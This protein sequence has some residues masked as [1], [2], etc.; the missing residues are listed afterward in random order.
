VDW[1]PSGCD[2][3]FDELRTAAEVNEEEFGGAI[4]DGEWLKM[5]TVNPAKA[6]ALDAFVGKLARSLKA[7]ITALRKLDD[8]PT[9]S[10]M[11]T[12]L[13]DVQMVWVGGDLL[14]ASKAILDVYGRRQ[15]REPLS[16][17]HLPS[18]LRSRRATSRSF[19]FPFD[20][21]A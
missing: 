15:F 19:E 1:N 20:V 10:V 18:A 8:D 9:K 5:I 6:L 7:D 17:L 14:Y 11:K 12:H 13:Q 16:I 3:I 2:H 21:T 4:P